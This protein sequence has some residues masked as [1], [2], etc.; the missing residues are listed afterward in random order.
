MMLNEMSRTEDLYGTIDYKPRN[1]FKNLN[2]INPM[3]MRYANFIGNF[4]NEQIFKQFISDLNPIKAEQWK[5]ASF[6]M[7]AYLIFRSPGL[8]AVTIIF[9]TVDLT[10]QRHSW[11]KLLRCINI[12]VMPIICLLIFGKFLNYWIY[13]FPISCVLSV[14]VFF[15]SRTDVAPRYNILFAFMCLFGLTVFMFYI[16]AE[17]TG[18]LKTFSTILNISPETARTTVMAWSNCVSHF[19]ICYK[20][21]KRGYYRLAWAG[22]YGSSNF[23]NYICTTIDC[24]FLLHIFFIVLLVGL[25]ILFIIKTNVSTETNDARGGSMGPTTAIYSM[26]LV[27]LT[28]ISILMTKF[29]A[30][31]SIAVSMFFIYFVYLIYIILDELAF[32]HPYG[33]D[34]VLD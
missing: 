8:F 29:M 11:S 27:L 23:G 26:G 22:L 3:N 7:K 12:I 16:Q 28:M 25:G 14:I 10:E 32:V 1:W 2:N 6:L 19:I 15:T 31:K 33:S 9:P 21:T 24:G 5:K 34:H 20:L 13:A 30:R 4:Q 17:F 18:V